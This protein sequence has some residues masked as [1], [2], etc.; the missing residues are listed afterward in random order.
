[1]SEIVEEI[2]ADAPRHLLI[3]GYGINFLDVSG[4]ILL[5][6]EARRR[7]QMGRRLYLCRLNRDV[8]RFL[9]HGDFLETIGAE[10][11][12]HT[13]YEAIARIFT[14]LDPEVCRRCRARI[15]D[16][17][18]SVPREG[19]AETAAVPAPDESRR[20]PLAGSV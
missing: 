8:Q 12:F 6:E 17:C 1:V 13:E 4:A 20:R 18:R 19:E 9:E 14:R 10:R 7:R 16:E 2:D 3:L 15:F 11:I 5:A